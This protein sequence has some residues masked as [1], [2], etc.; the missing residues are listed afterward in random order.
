MLDNPPVSHTRTPLTADGPGPADRLASH[1]CSAAVSA[2]M[3]RSLTVILIF[4]PCDRSASD[5]VIAA[6]PFH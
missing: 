3:L 5:A 2:G 6:S 4:S 1:S